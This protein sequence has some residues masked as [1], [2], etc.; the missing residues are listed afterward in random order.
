MKKN[1]LFTKTYLSLGLLLM[2]LISITNGYSQ[3]TQT[4]T[5]TG[6]S[7]WTV[8]TG[9]NG[10]ITVEVWGAGGSGGGCAASKDRGGSGGTGGTYSRSVFT[11]VVSGTTYYLYIAPAT[12]GTSGANGT[13]GGNS[14]FNTSNVSGTL[15]ANG[16]LGGNVGNGAARTAITTGSIGTTIFAGGSTLAGSSS[17]GSAGGAGGNSGGAGGIAT[18]AANNSQTAGNAGTQAGGGGSGASTGGGAGGSA[19]AG[20]DGAQG[21]IRITYPCPA[22]ILTSTTV[23]SSICVGAAASITL[24]NTV[25]SVLPTGTY[26]VTYN[27]GT[28]N[29]ATGLTATMIVSTAGTGTFTTTA[30]NNSGATGITIT[31]ITRGTCSSTISTANTATITVNAAPTANA[32]GALSVICQ[33][34]TTAALGGSF[35]GSATSAI[36]STTSGGS[37]ANNDG[38]TPGTTTWTAPAGFTGTAT[39]TLT[40]SGGGC[41]SAIVSKTQLVSG[42][43]INAGAAV[44]GICQGGTTGA[45]GGSFG[46][47]ATGAIWSDGGIGGTFTNNSGTTPGTTTW[48][49]PTLYLGTATLTNINRRTLRYY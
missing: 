41:S 34:G 43:T 13:N 9:V 19:V 33:N 12:S 11:G 28:P 35:G 10:D 15:V 49:P 20:G 45:L 27:L 2:S 5:T 22:Y 1:T 7:T 46:G 40:T 16:G 31:N 48:T 39:L 8:P 32:G 47:S 36:W 4:I 18:T 44:P 24:T 3:I 6:S 26:T 23:S 14:W 29:A 38:S 25:T 30:L 17:G 21:E 37:F 42:P